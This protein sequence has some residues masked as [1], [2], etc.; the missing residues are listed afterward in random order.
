MS[1][2]GCGSTGSAAADLP[3]RLR[4]AS[5]PVARMRVDRRCRAELCGRQPDRHRPAPATA[6]RDRAGGCCSDLAR[7]GAGRAWEGRTAAC[8]ANS[9]AARNRPTG[10]RKISFAPAFALWFH[11]L[12]PTCGFDAYPDRSRGMPARDVAKTTRTTKSRTPFA[13][14]LNGE[15]GV[16]RRLLVA[17][18]RAQRTEDVDLPGQPQ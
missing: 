5:L 12:R 6:D 9:A 1:A 7:D 15:S 2:G 3:V 13:A 18:H 17:E 14:V 10:G 8:R 4:R 16:S 11:P